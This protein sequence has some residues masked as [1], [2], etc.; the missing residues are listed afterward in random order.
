MEATCGVSIPTQ[1]FAFL[2]AF[3]PAFD[4]G[5]AGVREHRLEGLKPERDARGSCPSVGDQRQGACHG[6]HRED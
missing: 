1:E 3:L 4:H 6:P 5:E 2:L